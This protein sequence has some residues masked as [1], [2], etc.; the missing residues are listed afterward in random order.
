MGSIAT[1]FGGGSAA[2]LVAEL[3]P[4]VGGGWEGVPTTP[5]EGV[6]TTPW[7]GVP[8]TPLVTNGDATF[9]PNR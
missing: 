5:C 4:V 2:E 8:T 9:N 7:E 6:P 1:I 3:S